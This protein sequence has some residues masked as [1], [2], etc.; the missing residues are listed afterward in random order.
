MNNDVITGNAEEVSEGSLRITKCHFGWILEQY[1]MDV[2]RVDSF[3]DGA[4]EG[5]EQVIALSNN[6]K[7]RLKDI[8]AKL[9]DIR[10]GLQLM[11]NCPDLSKKVAKRLGRY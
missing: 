6:S 4:G 11:K 9:I 2:G 10:Q 5:W 7:T 1:V 3:S 8:K